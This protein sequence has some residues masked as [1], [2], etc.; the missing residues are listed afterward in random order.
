MDLAILGRAIGRPEADG[1]RQPN[2]PAGAALEGAFRGSLLC[3]LLPAELLSE[4]LQAVL[5]GG[6]PFDRWS[7][8]PRLSFA[9]P[10]KELVLSPIEDSL[11]L[12]GHCIPLWE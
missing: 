11:G 12:R 1:N 6:P 9:G 8:S 4:L 2:P 3:L 5:D 7:L 10:S